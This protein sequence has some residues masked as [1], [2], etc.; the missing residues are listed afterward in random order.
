L[1]TSLGLNFGPNGER[2]R[3]PL[4]C[5]AGPTRS[6]VLSSRSAAWRRASRIKA[7]MARR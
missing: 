3:A 2:Q 4:G 6:G 5:A 1:M 7:P